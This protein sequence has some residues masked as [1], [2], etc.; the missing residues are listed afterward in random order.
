MKLLE[1][2]LHQHLL[3]HITWKMSYWETTFSC[4]KLLITNSSLIPLCTG[5]GSSRK[6]HAYNCEKIP[7]LYSSCTRTAW[8]SIQNHFNF[9]ITYLPYCREKFFQ[10]SWSNSCSQLHAE[11]C[12][13]IPLFRGKIINRFSGKSKVQLKK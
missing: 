2:E 1:S 3:P 9:P 5:I 6:P 13:S 8:G 11:H 12:S 7:I 4:S 10:V